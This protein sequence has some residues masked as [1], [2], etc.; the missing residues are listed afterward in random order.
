M[1]DIQQGSEKS[2]ATQGEMFNWQGTKPENVLEKIVKFYQ[3]AVNPDLSLKEMDK[4]LF[5]FLKDKVNPTSRDPLFTDKEVENWSLLTERVE[6]VSL[7]V[8]QSLYYNIET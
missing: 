1:S 2:N 4:L 5:R 8:K 7:E 6:S 3:H